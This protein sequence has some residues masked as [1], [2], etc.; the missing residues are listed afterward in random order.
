VDETRLPESVDMWTNAERYM[1]AVSSSYRR[2]NWQTQ[3][4]HVELWCEKSTV[5]GS[6][7]PIVQKWGVTTR[8]CHGYASCGQEM[9]V[10]S[11][12][13]GIRKEIIVLY[14]DDHDPSGVQMEEDVHQRAERASGT[15]FE[16]R[17]LAIHREDIQEFDLPPQ[18]I[19]DKDSRAASFRRQFGDNA[20]TVELDALPV[21]ELR[22]RIDE[23]IDAIVDHEQWDRQVRIQDVELNCIREFAKTIKT[24]PQIQL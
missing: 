22:T 15:L 5:L 4:T 14:L 17:R 6:V 20:A 10:G 3:L 1:E 21:E 18:R 19:K 8:V 9:D 2:D 23:A 11:L 16:L 12:F 24:L 7:R 13:E